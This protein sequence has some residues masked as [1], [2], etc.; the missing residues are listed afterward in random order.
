MADKVKILSFPF[1]C[2]DSSTY[3]GISDSCGRNRTETGKVIM[4]LPEHVTDCRAGDFAPFAGMVKAMAEKASVPVGLHLDHSFS[5]EQVYH[6][7]EAGFTPVMFD[8]SGDSLEENIRRTK[9]CRACPC[10]WGGCEAELGSVGLAKD[11]DNEKQIF[12]QNRKQWSVSVKRQ[13]WIFWQLLTEMPM[14]IIH[15]L[16]D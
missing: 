5:E 4:L 8:A 16:R 10:S 12:I 1:I 11:N 9:G 14:E 7:I 13:A 2:L 6:A 15:S 3:G